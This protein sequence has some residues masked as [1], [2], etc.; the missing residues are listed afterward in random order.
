M[1]S[2]IIEILKR[3]SQGNPVKYIELVERKASDLK[4]DLGNPRKISSKKRK[5][6]QDSLEQ[7][8]DFGIITIDHRDNILSGHQRVEALIR[9]K[10]D[11]VVVVCKRYVGFSD[12]ELKTINLKANTH[13]GEWDLNLLAQWTADLTKDVSVDI[14]KI[15]DVQEREIRDMELIRYEK[16][17]YVMI[18]CRNEIDYLNLV[19][20]LGIEGK[21]VKICHTAKGDR[22]INAR[23]IWYDQI[24]CQIKA[25]K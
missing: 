9:S 23:A 13:A 10:G 12:P 15:D 18:V 17:D 8:G 7:Y 22:K 5:E 16:Y 24:E 6:L 14:P 25:K 4:D 2:E 3:D 21:K 20:D 1:K 11:N 19:R